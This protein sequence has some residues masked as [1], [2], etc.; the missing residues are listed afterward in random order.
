MIKPL[1]CGTGLFSDESSTS[2]TICPFNNYCSNI[3]TSQDEVKVCPRGYICAEG[4]GVKPYNPNHA[5]PAGY[6]CKKSEKYE[7]PKGT[8]NAV[9]AAEDLSWCISVPEGYFTDVA[10]ST[11]FE[12]NLCKRGYYCP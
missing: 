9:L 4:L 8:Y 10:A 3:T 11:S 2:C 6:Y 7:C 12:N 1:V 5:C